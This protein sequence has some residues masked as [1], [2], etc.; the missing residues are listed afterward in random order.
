MNA[1]VTIIEVEIV[2]G[3]IL[4]CAFI[5]VYFTMP[6]YTTIPGRALMNLAWAIALVLGTSIFRIF[7]RGEGLWLDIIRVSGLGYVCAALAVQLGVL[8][9]YR[10]QRR[11]DKK[12]SAQ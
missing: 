1:I 2:V 10:R 12:E 4:S 8:I 11:N 5:G 3:F 6:W 7:W 9:Y